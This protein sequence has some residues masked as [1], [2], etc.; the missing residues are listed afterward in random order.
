MLAK[1]L[2]QM[3]KELLPKSETELN[4]PVTSADSLP[5]TVLGGPQGQRRMRANSEP[6]PPVEPGEI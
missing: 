2:M 6:V 4:T 5:A 3:L 1:S